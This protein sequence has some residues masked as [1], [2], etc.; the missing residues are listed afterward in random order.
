MTPDV[1]VAEVVREDIVKLHTAYNQHS[2]EN[3]DEE[4]APDAA[5]FC[6]P[7]IAT[8]GVERKEIRARRNNGR[9]EKEVDEILTEHGICC[10]MVGESVCKN[11]CTKIR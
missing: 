3:D 8:R 4:N 11:I 2:S 6:L 7:I 1:S 9:G 10:E 5:K